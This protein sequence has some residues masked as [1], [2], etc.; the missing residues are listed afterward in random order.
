MA[1]R[2][3]QPTA[4]GLAE[5]PP[6]PAQVYQRAL[7]AERLAHG[8]T[9]LALKESAEENALLSELLSASTAEGSQLSVK[10]ASHEQAS[11][12]T[13]EVLAS[14][15]D[16]SSSP[17]R[18]ALTVMDSSLSSMSI[19]VRGSLSSFADQ[20]PR[21]ED[22]FAF[23]DDGGDDREVGTGTPTNSP[24][25]AATATADAFAFEPPE[26]PVAQP[27]DGDF[28]F[29]DGP[30][31]NEPAALAHEEEPFSPRDDAG[32]DS[33]QDTDVPAAPESPEEMN[34]TCASCSLEFYT[35]SGKTVCIDCRFD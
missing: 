3:P 18:S 9:R 21:R 29:S 16:A 24:E 11:A 33:G 28:E 5:A 1:R 6:D 26:T 4:A 2:P 17:T 15:S 10:L 19:S 22:P 13:M 14:S 31:E 7:A 25:L 8:C 23:A 27:S 32:A 30:A 35:A 34:A 20:S 12:A